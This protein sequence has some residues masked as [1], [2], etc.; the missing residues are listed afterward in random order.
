MI[1]YN[2]FL[3]GKFA[4]QKKRA[5][6]F[7]W[8]ISIFSIAGIAI[9][10]IALM[11]VIGVMSG[12]SGELKRKIIGAYP[13]ITIEGRPYIY[14]YQEIMEKV[15]KNVPEVKGISPYISTQVIYKSQRYMMG[16]ILRGIDP[17]FEDNVT[18]I[19]KFLKKGEMKDISK[20]VFL[21]SELA[22]ELEVDVG[23]EIWVITGILAREK[24]AV[25]KGIVESGIYAFDSSMGF[26]SLEDPVLGYGGLVHGIGIRIDNIYASEDVAKRIR[27]LLEGEYTVSTWIQKNKILFAALAMERKAMAIILGLIILVASFNISSTLMITVY[28]KVKE[29]GILRA[30]GL[31]SKDIEKIFI[32]QG[33]ILGGKGLVCGLITGGFLAYL[34]KRYQFI[35]IPEFIYDLSRLPIEISLSDIY[36]IVISVLII[37]TL[38]SLYPARRAARLNPN[39]AIRNG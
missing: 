37:V 20:G 31:S 24:M 4:G 10:V 9:G 23:D 13:I 17:A 27:K 35:R 28:R 22:K 39:E 5:D 8:F 7:L 6:R 25:V 33:L 15:S 34:L 26:F 14:N 21:G 29:I 16:G 12:F 36:W 38:A 2:F 32:Y 30:L 19:G 1:S 3:S 11:L 18:N